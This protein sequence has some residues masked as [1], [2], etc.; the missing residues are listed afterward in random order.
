MPRLQLQKVLNLL[1]KEL[2][3]MEQNPL[4]TPWR[5]QQMPLPPEKWR[6]L[7][8]MENQLRKKSTTLT[9]KE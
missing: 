6:T 2:P 7:V 1:L 3:L 9:M 8:W 5:L 4:L